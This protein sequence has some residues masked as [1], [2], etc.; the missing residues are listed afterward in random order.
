MKKP[1][2]IICDKC[3]AP[4]V[5]RS[6]RKGEFYGCSR[7]PKCRNTK[8]I[9][10]AETNLGTHNEA[11]S[12]VF[13]SEKFKQPISWE[14]CPRPSFIANHQYLNC[15]SRL[16]VV[17]IFRQLDENILRSLQQWCLSELNTVQD[18]FVSLPDKL[19][20]V[21]TV[22]DKILTRGKITL[23]SLA[24]ER[25]F[26]NSLPNKPFD[27]QYSEDR[28]EIELRLRW[29]DGSKKLRWDDDLRRAIFRIAKSFT[30]TGL[31]C[32]D[33]EE[34]EI[35]YKDV[36][37]ELLDP[38][39]MH[40]VHPQVSLMNL[41]GPE[42]S[43]EFVGSRVDFVLITPFGERA[44]I[45]IDGPQH[46]EKEEAKI[47][48]SRDAALEDA[49]I[50]V[51]RIPTQ[52]VKKEAGPNLEAV[53][54][55]WHETK[56]S[57]DAKELLSKE[58]VQVIWGPILASRI[59][60]AL[61]YAIRRRILLP[62]AK[63]WAIRF[64]ERDVKCA[65][66]AVK[67]WL[68]LMSHI[69]ALYG[70]NILPSQ[71]FIDINSSP[72]E[73]PSWILFKKNK[74]VY[75]KVPK[76]N[77]AGSITTDLWIDTSALSS[78]YDECS[79]SIR[80]FIN[81]IPTLSI[82]S[83]FIDK[84]FK[85][86]IFPVK[87]VKIKQEN[88]QKEN[89]LYFLNYLFRKIEF[90]EGQ[91]ETIE[92]ALQGLD[93]IV[94]LPTGGGKS[95]A[96]QLPA[97][98]TPGVT[99]IIDPL[100][101]LINDQRDNLSS[102]GVDRSIGIT[103]QIT[104]PKMME[105]LIQLFAQGEYY[106]CFI[107]PERLQTRPFRNSLKQLTSLTPINMVI[108]DEAHCVSE[109]GHDFRTAY[110]RL[111]RSGRE[112][113]S[114][115]AGAP[116][117]LALTGTA[118][119]SVLK[120]I[121]RELI[122]TDIGAI[123]TPSTFDRKE[124][125]FR[126]VRAE[127]KHKEAKLLGYLRIL[128]SYFN[129]GESTLFSIKEKD[130]YSGLI[131]CPHVGGNFG[132]VEVSNTIRRNLGIEI[133]YYSGKTPKNIDRDE[134]EHI[135]EKIA[136]NF[137]YNQIPLMCCTKAFGMGI[138]K[139]N[140]RYTVHY[141]IPPSLEAFYQ[142]AGR[143]GRDRRKAFCSVIFSDDYPERSEKLLDPNMKIEE[144][145]KIFERNS[146]DYIPWEDRDD[147]VRAL[148]FQSQSFKGI[149]I[150]KSYIEIVLSY[151]SDLSKGQTVSI[152]YPYEEGERNAYEKAVH[153][154]LL[155]GIVKDYTVDYSRKKIEIESSV[156][157][158]ELIVKSIREYIKLYDPR[159]ASLI[160]KQLRQYWLSKVPNT[161]IIKC[162]KCTRKLRIPTDKGKLKIT[163]PKCKYSFSFDPDKLIQTNLREFIDEAID[164][165]LNFTY[166]VI[167][168]SRRRAIWEAWS[169]A[170]RCNNDKTIRTRINDYLQKT[171]YT[172]DILKLLESELINIQGWRQIL[173]NVAS[174]RDAEELRGDVARNLE[175]FPSHYGLLV[176]R[177]ITEAILHNDAHNTVKQF[178][179]AGVES[180]RGQ[181]YKGSEEEVFEILKWII[182]ASNDFFKSYFEFVVSL[183]FSIVPSQ[184]LAEYFIQE[185]WAN[186]STRIYPVNTIL[187][188]VKRK[189]MQI[190]TKA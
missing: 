141:G 103:S 190:T 82:R 41:L 98:L 168:Q 152:Q 132:I 163:C 6:G 94:L 102:V 121:Q 85:S 162:A 39:A 156:C 9:I 74:L 158:Y 139:P 59:Q 154:L 129:V 3:R 43:Q 70:I 13:D 100:K 145:A 170:K 136:H 93:T 143:A 78:E 104:D 182:D 110:L 7:F 181:K 11:E 58:A 171:K 34:E 178:I 155:L 114:S 117:I 89:L 173:T 165:L 166:D 147:V 127:S 28:G 112:Y 174:K 29:H 32:W 72:K 56:S 30:P 23:V 164:A 38:F 52:E 68:E 77:R 19:S 53:Q 183:C 157:N 65:L 24:F 62:G 124:L 138:D 42:K 135:K 26:L 111:G 57:S 185:Y 81:K 153:R 126:I 20:Q 21:L 150:E 125:S 109:W 134:W 69:T 119:R 99:V 96:Y 51:F 50:Q 79:P 66:L 37:P 63:R 106:F 45:E 146:D 61:T 86:T 95:L 55:F 46:K 160:E 48:A 5:I 142:E 22:V 180:L 54:E 4:M 87:S 40:Y 76:I 177:S 17:E 97:L 120:D 12:E 186:E 36:L 15:A 130:T 118:S 83:T 80:K 169:W 133:S 84:P 137:K 116:P 149:A 179:N 176:L 184:E 123:I 161:Q 67:D 71:L 92:R 27:I 101:S 115:E 44:V 105:Q 148:Y 18:E 159:R 25:E 122:I 107:A 88:I 35:F 47:D 108:V 64:V 8:E 75:E 189:V 175:D 172:K 188:E 14:G 10:E 167:E 33:S 140:I 16:S 90:W 31:E 73:K 151:I 144:V 2:E 128:A 60:Y 91:I 49:G 113:C 187:E 1:L 131:F